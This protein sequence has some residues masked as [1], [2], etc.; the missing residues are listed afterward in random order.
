[1]ADSRITL[2]STGQYDL[3]LALSQ[4]SINA[5]LAAMWDLDGDK[6]TTIT[7]NGA[8]FGMLDKMT[9]QIGEPAVQ[10]IATGAGR[11][12]VLFRLNF[13]SGTGHFFNSELEDT[14]P[15]SLEGFRVAFK[16]DI[17]E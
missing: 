9:G 16:V 4:D 15:K 17:G 3:L 11:G 6:M 2:T 10:V 13:V 1:M 8:K 14:E 7:I 5:A 12:S